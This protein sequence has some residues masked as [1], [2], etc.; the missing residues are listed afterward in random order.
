MPRLKQDPI[1]QLGSKIKNRLLSTLNVNL[2]IY[3]LILSFQ[4]LGL[5]FGFG[6]VSVQELFSI[7]AVNA[8]T[9]IN[10]AI[11]YQGKLMDSSG[12]L[13]ANG[14]YSIKFTIYNQPVGGTQLWS[15]STTSGLPSGT[16]A[17]LDVTVNN[18]LFSI[19]LGDIN[20]NQVAFPEGLFT[21]IIY[22]LASQ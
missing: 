12:N 9:G 19:L 5:V 3:S 2:F 21:T 1:K 10:Q 20:N 11:N 18:G 16:P 17:S 15:A 22:I 6:S 14:S 8:S 4:V 7:K 13:V